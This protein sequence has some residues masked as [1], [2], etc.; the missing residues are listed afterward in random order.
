MKSTFIQIIICFIT[1]IPSST[2]KAQKNCLSD[3][4]LE[5]IRLNNPA[6][7]ENIIDYNRKVADYKNSLST[8]GAEDIID[9]PVVIHI[10]HNTMYPEQNISDALIQS[11]MTVLNEDFN[12]LNTDASSTPLAFQGIAANPKFRFSLACRDPFG[13]Y[14]TGIIRKQ[15][16]VINFNPESAAS[17]VQSSQNVGTEP[18]FVGDDPW[19]TDKYLNIWVCNNLPKASYGYIYDKKA[20]NG[21]IDGVVIHYEVFGKDNN[22]LFAGN[23]HGRTVT[24]EVGHW[25]NCYHIFEGRSCSGLG[26]L[27][28]DTPQQNNLNMVCPNFP[29]ISCPNQPN[30]D[31]FMNYMDYTYDECMNLFSNDQKNRMR[32]LFEPGGFRRSIIENNNALKSTRLYRPQNNSDVILIKTAQGSNDIGSTSFTYTPIIVEECKKSR[33]IT[34]RIVQRNSGADIIINGESASLR[35]TR[36]NATCELEV[37]IPM[38]G[39]DVVENYSFYVYVPLP[40]YDLSPNPTSDFLRIEQRVKQN[41]TQLLETPYTVTIYGTSNQPVKKGNGNRGRADFDM[42]NQPRG[43]YQV[44]IETNGRVV[45]KRVMIQR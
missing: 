25:L 45:S 7:Y 35:L 31:M 32:T 3:I 36:G 12:R 2:I 40:H 28:M 6:I 38:V 34:W 11:Q 27:C 24:H 8:R 29:K 9:I 21:F 33:P 22:L 14:T 13:N 5:Q 19:P 17:Q 18:Q 15:T 4:N 20:T 26:D 39:G 16:R 1:L 37:T 44:L 10:L 43:Q 42:S 23:K 41:D 30:G